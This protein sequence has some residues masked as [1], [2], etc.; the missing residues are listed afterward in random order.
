MEIKKNKSGDFFKFLGEI[1][2]AQTTEVEVGWFKEQG[3]HHSGVT[4]P[5][6]AKIHLN[7]VRV[8]KRDI[9]GVSL[10]LNDPSTDPKIKSLIRS[11][12]K[13]KGMSVESLF[14]SLGEIEKKRVMDT[15]GDPRLGITG[16]PTPLVDTGDWRSTTDFRVVKK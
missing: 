9:L 10:F 16:N 3:T 15:F 8:P 1:E 5:E 6:L 2:E 13:R 11:W 7:G 14:N 12:I 4:Y